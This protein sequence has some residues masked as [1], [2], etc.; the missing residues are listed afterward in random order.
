MTT[1]LTPQDRTAITELLAR[2]GH[3]VDAGDL[4]RLGELFTDDAVHDFT[5]LGL[6]APVHG[7]AALRQ[8]ALDL[9]EGN[10]VGHHI[11]NIV[12]EPI[13]ADRVH[14]RSKGIG[15]NADGTCASVT[16]DDTIA[17]TA[18]GWRITRRTARAHR[19][20]LG[21]G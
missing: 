5:D 10:P 11:T 1:T 9:G 14:A 21:A 7:T 18:H 3:L 15:I 6:P 8:A 4:D 13:T 2:H 20:P 16:Y 17:R 19:K 12:L